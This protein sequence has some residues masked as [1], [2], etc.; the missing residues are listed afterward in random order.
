MADVFQKVRMEPQPDGSVYIG[1]GVEDPDGI[2]D[3]H[4]D[5]P[6]LTAQWAYCR[7]GHAHG[8]GTC[9]VATIF[10]TQQL[11]D[12]GQPIAGTS[13]KEQLSAQKASILSRRAALVAEPAM[14]TKQI[15]KIDPATKQPVLDVKGDPVMTPVPD[16][17]IGI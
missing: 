5:L 12:K 7:A 4:G 10:G 1:I 17:S 3:D 9:D 14:P 2:R 6:I 13:L 8:W 16:K 15:P 11:N